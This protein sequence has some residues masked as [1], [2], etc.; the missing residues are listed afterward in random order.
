MTKKSRR[1]SKRSD[2]SWSLKKNLSGRSG[3]MC[4]KRW[5]E[6]K[7]KLI[8]LS[9]CGRKR[10]RAFCS[11]CFF[12]DVSNFIFSRHFMCW[13]TFF[14]SCREALLMI[15]AEKEEREWFGF[16]WPGSSARWNAGNFSPQSIVD[17]PQRFLNFQSSL[18]WTIDRGP[19]IQ[20]SPRVFF[21]HDV[22]FKTHLPI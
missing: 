12:L 5:L 16:Q 3:S 6:S 17:C 8:T 21:D 9:A 13:A 10:L 2:S 4:H 11:T 7:T 1:F 14:I 19:W 15:M 22:R 18:L 20:K